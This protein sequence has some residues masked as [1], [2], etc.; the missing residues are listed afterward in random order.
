MFMLN[1]S[2]PGCFIRTY[3]FDGHLSL[4]HF[5]LVKTVKEATDAVLHSS[6]EEVGRVF[7]GG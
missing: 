2:A 7:V 4:S 1:A 6:N 3:T 5:F